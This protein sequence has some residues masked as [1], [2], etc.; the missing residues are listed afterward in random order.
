MDPELTP[1]EV[2][3]LLAAYALDAVDDD[4]RDAVER[5]LA[6]HPDAAAEV[7]A[8][9][10]AAAMLAYTGGPVPEGVWDALAPSLEA[11][12]ARE[13]RAQGV[14][15]LTSRRPQPEPMPG[16]PPRRGTHRVRWL[17]A[18]AVAAVLVVGA[19]VGI[20]VA[21]SGGGGTDQQA[22]TDA[23]R[24]ARNAPGAQRVTL[25]DSDG[26]PLATA[27]VLRD[28]TGYLTSD[29]PALRQGRTY[30]LW[31]L[32]DSD[33]VSLGVMGRD[34]HVVAFKVKTKGKPSGLA[35]TNEVDGGVEVT[36][37]QPTAV[38]LIPSA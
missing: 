21:Q 27:V 22:L 30:Q 11:R 2:E 32:V 15:P 19:A 14:V 6:D 26:H 9:R 18:A 10:H 13:Q 31:A 36:H 33:R 17:A 24:A 12:R 4:E 25:A 20:V 5:Y 8:F 3:D 1:G 38:G 7:Q 35:V 29:L 23:A 16:S 34:P 37:N 28:G